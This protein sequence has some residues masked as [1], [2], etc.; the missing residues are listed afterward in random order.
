M[1]S[2]TKEE[3]RNEYPD[4]EVFDNQ[5]ELGKF[6]QG[7]GVRHKIEHLTRRWPNAKVKD[8]EIYYDVAELA[9]E[10]GVAFFNDGYYIIED[11]AEIAEYI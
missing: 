6:I 11:F 3:L 10:K 2:M 1:D 5:F 8:T 7:Y 4:G 9:L